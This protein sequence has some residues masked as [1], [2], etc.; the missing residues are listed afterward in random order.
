VTRMAPPEAP[1]PDNYELPREVGDAIAGLARA[2]LD[3]E[4]PLERLAAIRLVEQRLAAVIPGT[5]LVL[6]I[7]EARDERHTFR[8]IGEAYGVTEQ[9]AH[10]LSRRPTDNP[11]EA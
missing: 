3:I 11:E 1:T 8:A 10:Q 4:D 9:R 5:V 2:L 6:A 7:R